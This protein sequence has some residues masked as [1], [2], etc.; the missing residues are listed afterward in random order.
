MSAT[1]AIVKPTQLPGRQFLRQKRIGRPPTILVAED[2]E[3]TR[4]LLC[5]VLG[6]WGYRVVEACN[7]LEAV[8]AAARERPALILMDGS[9]PFLDGLSATRRIRENALLGQVKILAL[10]GWGS[11]S[12]NDAALAAGCDDCIVKPFDSEQL[13]QHLVPLL[14]ASVIAEAIPH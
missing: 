8:E 7:G 3:D 5:T 12:Y 1:A 2:H 9:L 10:N 13:R 6:M 14:D 11:Q 4:D